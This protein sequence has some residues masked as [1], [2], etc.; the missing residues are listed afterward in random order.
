MAVTD[1]AANYFATASAPN[2]IELKSVITE[3]SK[4]TVKE[5]MLLF[6]SDGKA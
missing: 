5:H 1:A 2:Y 4:Q 6:E 3:A